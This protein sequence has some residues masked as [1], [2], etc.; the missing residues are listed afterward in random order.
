MFIGTNVYGWTQLAAKAGQAWDRDAAMAQAAAAGITGWEDAFRSAAEAGPVVAAAARH[1]LS[2]RSAYVFGAFHEPGLARASHDA[3]LSICDALMPEGVRAFVSNPDP[4]PDGKLKT[5]AQ[6][7]VQRDALDALGAALAARGARLLY[8]FHTPELQAAAREFHHM[9]AA[10]DPAHV[11]LCLDVHWLW[12]GA[13]NSQIALDDAIRLY[14]DRVDEVHLR[15]SQGGIWAETVG[16]G[17]VDLVRV[18]SM[19]AGRGAT[20]LVVL[21]HAYEAGTPMTLDPVAA[22]AES[23]RYVTDVFGRVG[24]A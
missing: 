19:L 8:H 6:L 20:P 11:C 13:G 12:R 22:H 5:D 2:L 4:L 23:V 7:A 17:D 9:L 16:G 10:T 18:A 1:G 15:Q 24:A 3:A 21:E 14:G